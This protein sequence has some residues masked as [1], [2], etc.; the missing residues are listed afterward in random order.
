MKEIWWSMVRWFPLAC[1]SGKL[2]YIWQILWEHVQYS[3]LSTSKTRIECCNGG[4]DY[5][6]LI[7]IFINY[8]HRE[9]M[10]IPVFILYILFN[11]VCFSVFYIFCIKINVSLNLCWF[12]LFHTNCVI[13]LWKGHPICYIYHSVCSSNIF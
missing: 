10:K 6:I 8:K 7:Y 2:T 5:F 11:F 4:S 9:N 3:M 1:I 12:A 13:S